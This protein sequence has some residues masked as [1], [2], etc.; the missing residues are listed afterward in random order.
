MNSSIM[1]I[2]EADVVLLVGCNPKY[3][4]PVFNSKILRQTRENNLKVN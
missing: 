4:A 3:E 2:E 1:G